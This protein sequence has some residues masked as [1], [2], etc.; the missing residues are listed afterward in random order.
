MERATASLF[1]AVFF[2]LFV[3]LFFLGRSGVWGESGRTIR[4]AR[5]PRPAPA[6]DIGPK[7]RPGPDRTR[8]GV[9]RRALPKNPRARRPL[10]KARTAGF[11]RNRTDPTADQKPPMTAKAVLRPES[12]IGEALRAVAL[13]MLA[14]ARNAIESPDRSDAVAV[15]GFRREMKRWRSLLRLLHPFVG[16]DADALQG[17]ARELS[18]ELRGARDPQSALDALDDLIEHGLLLSPRSIATL[19]RRIEELR[20]RGEQQAL[21]PA[22][23]Q[24]ISAMLADAGGAVERWP[25]HVLTFSDIAQQLAAHYRAARRALPDNWSQAGPEMLH[26]F[27]KRVIV[28]R[29]QMQLVEPLWPRFTAMWIAEAQRLRERLG[30]HQD[31][32]V[33]RALT[34][35]KAPLAHWR[36]RLVPA[37]AERQQ[38]HVVAAKRRASR[39]FVDKPAAFRRRLLAMW[40]AG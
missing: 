9:W 34:Q 37:I 28:H 7:E 22:M 20:G 39:L 4:P 11:A 38:R 3:F 2:F 32:E 12:A 16:E 25:L 14:D 36:S 24:R 1:G 17:G 8:R 13:G 35:P 31:L 27:R 23:R 10:A 26:E 33:L 29:Y 5:K 40:E 18:R 15:H 6:V 19:R 21:T 30:Q